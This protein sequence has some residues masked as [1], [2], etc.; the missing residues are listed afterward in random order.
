[1]ILRD[2]LWV[3]GATIYV[4]GMFP[5]LYFY[6]VDPTQRFAEFVT[7]FTI[8]SIFGAVGLLFLQML[9]GA[10]YSRGPNDPA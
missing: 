10:W 9:L 8:I 5:L 6:Q 3:I 1:M 7:R 2:E 4:V